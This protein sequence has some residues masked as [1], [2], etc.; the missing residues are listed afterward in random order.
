MQR[1]D[2]LKAWVASLH[3]SKV[4]EL[5]FAAADADF[6]RYF[7][8]VFSTGETRIVMD[9]PPDKVDIAP[10]LYVRDVFARL[11]VPSIFACDRQRGFVEMEDLGKVTYLEALREPSGKDAAHRL[12]I[13]AVDTLIE[14]QVTSELGV[15]PDYSAMLLRKEMQLFV[16]WF[17]EKQLK[18]TLTSQQQHVWQEAEQ[19]LIE[20][21]LAQP[22]V[23]VHRDFIVRNLMLS[24]GR[25]GVLDFQDAVYG[26]ITYDLVSLLRDAFIEF[27]EAF[28]L[29]IVV[30]YWEKARRAG[31]PVKPT[32][33][34][35][36]R[37]FEWMG[38]QRHLKVA[39]IFCRLSWR[40]DKPQYLPEVPRFIQYLKKTTRRY[41]ELNPLF[42][43]ITTLAGEDELRTGYTF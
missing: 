7:R 32:I 5:A 22:R 34:E 42:E 10:Y 2:E 20:A 36:Y 11:N 9:A 24:K 29:D 35:F 18:Q 14:L 3:P 23:F 17:V 41:R 16:R 21:A 6:R 19:L 8:V 27:D 25:P 37:D 4:F 13:E 43:L 28:V 39:G 15:L 26:P 30:R 33:D 1:F 12:L 38:V 31:L 40:D